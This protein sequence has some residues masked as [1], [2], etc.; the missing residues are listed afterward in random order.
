MSE[1][2][3]LPPEE[4]TPFGRFRKL[5]KEVFNLPPEEVKRRQVEWESGR[6]GRR[7]KNGPEENDPQDS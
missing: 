5:A 1:E 4:E 2:K 3:H 6:K 7:K